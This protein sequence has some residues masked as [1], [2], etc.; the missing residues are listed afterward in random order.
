MIAAVPN[1]FRAF[2]LGGIKK[3]DS[4]DYRDDRDPR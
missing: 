4:A 1:M 3:D 2:M